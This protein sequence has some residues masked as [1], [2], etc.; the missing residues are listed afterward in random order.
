MKVLKRNYGHRNVIL[1]LLFSMVYLQAIYSLS[2]GLS[3]LG[4]ESVEL[5]IK[6]HYLILSLNLVTVYMILTLRKHS[7]KVLLLCLAFITGKNFILLS[8]SFNKLILG[9]SFAY[10]IFAFYFY[11]T[12]ELETLKASHNPNF[13]Q[14]DLEI[15]ARFPLAGKIESLSGEMALDVLITNMDDESCFTFVSSD[16]AREAIAA[17]D[18]QAKYRLVAEYEGVKFVQMAELVAAYDRGIGLLL[19]NERQDIRILNWSDLYKV[20]LDRGLFA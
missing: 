11:I 9:L 19:V 12:W 1:F 17:L 10:L 14:N 20:C 16:K 4:L 8:A 6:N 18:A 7:D 2:L 15:K 3:V 13:S 5:F